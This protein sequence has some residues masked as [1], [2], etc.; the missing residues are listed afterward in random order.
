MTISGHILYYYRPV[1]F[2]SYDYK[3]HISF[4]TNINAIIS[5]Y[6]IRHQPQL[7]LTLIFV[8]SSKTL[9]L[10]LNMGFWWWPCLPI[11]SCN[12]LPYH[13]TPPPEFP[14]NFHIPIIGFA[15]RLFNSQWPNHPRGQRIA[16][17]R[18]VQL[19]YIQENS[20]VGFWERSLPRC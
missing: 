3:G 19:Q 10:F 5:S 14:W 7:L 8:L 2:L 1:L 13:P 4:I 20:W 18:A 6:H 11:N 15:L 17:G 12:L 9:P 16:T